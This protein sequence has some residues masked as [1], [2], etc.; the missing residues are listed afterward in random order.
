MSV[1]EILK[2]AEALSA[3]DRAHLVDCLLVSLRLP[4]NRG[5]DI[6]DIKIAEGRLEEL[7]SGTAD[8]V[9]LDSF[10]TEVRQR[11]AIE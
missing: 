10:L 8:S 4:G 11:F 7:K 6:G 1:D 2:K 9:S 3:S 5:A